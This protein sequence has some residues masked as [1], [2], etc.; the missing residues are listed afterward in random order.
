MSEIV[1]Y[2]DESGDTAVDVLL[3]VEGIS[4]RPGVL[5]CRKCRKDVRLAVGT[6]MERSRVL[7][8]IWFWSVS[9]HQ[10]DTRHVGNTIS[11]SARA[12]AIRDGISDAPQAPLRYGSP[13]S[14]QDQRA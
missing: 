7:L 5:R 9:D 14:G 13:G 6:V 11:T 1:F 12:I 2:S 8:S 10:Q 4:T 3:D